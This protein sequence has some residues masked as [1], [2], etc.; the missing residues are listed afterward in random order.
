MRT[1]IK[2]NSCEL[3]TDGSLPKVRPQRQR[4]LQLSTESGYG[5]ARLPREHLQEDHRLWCLSRNSQR[6]WW[7]RCVSRALLIGHRLQVTLVRDSNASYAKWM[8]IRVSVRRT[9]PN[10]RYDSH[11]N[12]CSIIDLPRFQPKPRLLRKQKSA[13]ELE[14]RFAIAEAE[15]KDKGQWWLFD[16]LS[17]QRLCATI[18][19]TAVDCANLGSEQLSAGVVSAI[20]TARYMRINIQNRI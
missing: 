2:W 5:S 9:L 8:S 18:V 10:A 7:L 4:E 13:S 19:G 6:Y 1:W 14:T 20:Y 16:I 12:F 15:D 3:I 17:L 11:R